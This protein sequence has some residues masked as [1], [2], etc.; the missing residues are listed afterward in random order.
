M[1]ILQEKT[2]LA[3]NE[4]FV[5][6][7]INE[8][9]NPSA[10]F[11]GDEYSTFQTAIGIKNQGNDEFKT[12]DYQKAV[13]AYGDAIT[14]LLSLG[15]VKCGHEL[16]ICYENRAAAY[17]HLNKFSLVIEDATKAIEADNTYAKAYFR[18]SRG[19]IVQKKPYSALEDI[20]W[21]CILERFRNEAYNKMAADINA[22]FG[23]GDSVYAIASIRNLAR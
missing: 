7:E 5:F 6:I 1:E 18:R 20:V 10:K 23:R 14:L 8:D 9:A 21:A 22:K 12:R 13:K 15:A 16:A 3:T 2:D 11:D 17:E 19:H 4:P